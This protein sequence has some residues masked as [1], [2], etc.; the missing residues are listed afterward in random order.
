MIKNKEEEKINFENKNK[1]LL[2]KNEI[3]A[4][5]VS[6]KLPI[7]GAKH[8]I[9]DMVITKATKIW[10]YLNFIKYKE[11]VINVVRQSC[12]VTK[13]TLHKK[14]TETTQNTIN[15]LSNLSE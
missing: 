6:W 3:L 1:E 5:N 12:I 14:P 8:L 10:P 4:E 7:Q 2:E 15:F 9:R 11:V 13:E